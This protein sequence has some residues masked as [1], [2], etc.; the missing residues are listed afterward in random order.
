MG[1]FLLNCAFGEYLGTKEA[2]EVIYSVKRSEK[3]ATPRGSCF[4]FAMNRFYEF[5]ISVIGIN[6]LQILLTVDQNSR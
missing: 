6:L 3:L 1:S 4:Q 5:Q 2:T